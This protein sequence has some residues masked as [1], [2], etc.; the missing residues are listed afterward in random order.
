MAKKTNIFTDDWLTFHDVAVDLSQMLTFV[1][2]Q[3]KMARDATKRSLDAVEKMGHPGKFGAA[4]GL[5]IIDVFREG[6]FTYRMPAGKRATSGHDIG[7]MISEVEGRFNNSVL[8]SL[9]EALETYAKKLF[10]AMLYQLRNERPL[11]DKGDFHSAIKTAHKHRGTPEYFRLYVRWTCRRDCRKAWEAFRNELDWGIVKQDGWESLEWLAV[12]DTLDRCR[13]F[14][15]HDEG[16]VAD[17]QWSAM[18][19][20]QRD[21]IKALM[22][23]S[24]LTGEDRILATKDQAYRFLEAIMAVSYAVYT[25]WFQIGLI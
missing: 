22:R 5:S 4:T 12:V 14:I 17:E 16:R 15:A 19:T 18:S 25:F 24:M 21:L 6:E 1:P 13:N 3:L 9:H 11:K 23:K 8:L 20:P 10:Q 2:W 7:P